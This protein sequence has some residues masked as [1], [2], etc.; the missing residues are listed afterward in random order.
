MWGRGR[1]GDEPTKD[2]DEFCL[3]RRIWIAQAD[4]VD[5]Q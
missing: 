4:R 3:R 2:D 5:G 1:G